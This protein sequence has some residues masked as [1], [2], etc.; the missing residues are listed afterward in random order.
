MKGVGRRR[1]AFLAVLTTDGR[2]VASGGVCPGAL[3]LL[4][5]VAQ[6][7]FAILVRRKRLPLGHG[8][9]PERTSDPFLAGEDGA[10]VPERTWSRFDI[11]PGSIP[12]VGHRGIQAARACGSCDRGKSGS[13]VLGCW[14]D[15][16][17]GCGSV[18]HMLQG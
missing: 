15:R 1:G 5:Q 6:V 11:S 17:R 4:F 14:P 18:P 3:L 9:A 8:E 16:V 13:R 7:A 10:E 2:G 12:R